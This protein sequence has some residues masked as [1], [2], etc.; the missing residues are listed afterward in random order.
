MRF[1]HLSV[2]IMV[3][4]LSIFNVVVGP[5]SRAFWSVKVDTSQFSV[6]TITSSV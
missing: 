6:L 4:R 2:M 1:H 3:A 5:G